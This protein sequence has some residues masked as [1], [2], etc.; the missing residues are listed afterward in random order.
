MKLPEF[1]FNSSRHLSLLLF[2]GSIQIEF[3]EPVMDADGIPVFFKGGKTPGQ[4]R[5]KKVKR[6][7][8]V[9][10]FGIKA[11]KGIKQNKD[12]NYSTDEGVLK[13]I[14]EGDF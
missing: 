7:Y 12:G 2:G 10:G 11:W 8:Y 14:A 9:R 6:D 1:N 3:I 13:R 5:T 4:I